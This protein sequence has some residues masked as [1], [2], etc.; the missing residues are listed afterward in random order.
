[1][2]TRGAPDEL[3]P[4]EID[5]SRAPD[6][7][8]QR[9]RADGRRGGS[10]RGRPTGRARRPGCSTRGSHSISASSSRAKIRSSRAPERI[11]LVHAVVGI[12]SVAVDGA[13]RVA[14][15]LGRPDALA[16]ASC[17]AAVVQPVVVAVV[18]EGRGGLGLVAQD[19]LD[20][21]GR[22]FA[23]LGCGGSSRSR[24]TSSIGHRATAAFRACA[25]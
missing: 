3:A 7:A 11:S 20:R 17:L 24:V 18:A 19:V 14:V 16:T 10:S 21:F 1:M 9:S 12:E 8:A 15:S 22:C 13:H 6:R 23:E 5:Q 2:W 4:S 25:T